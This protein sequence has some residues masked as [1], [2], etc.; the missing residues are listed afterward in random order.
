MV[1]ARQDHPRVR[2]HLQVEFVKNTFVLVDLAELGVEVLGDVERLD[3]LRI[4]AHVPDVHGQVVAR[5]EVIVARGREL[6]HADRVDD[7]GE[8]VLARRVIL[9][10]DF[11]GVA[12]ELRRHAV[13][14]QADVP[15]A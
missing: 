15:V 2:R 9:K 6:R 4:I 11:H 12:A 8:E 10:L 5:E 3:G 14:A 13:V 1:A 7:L